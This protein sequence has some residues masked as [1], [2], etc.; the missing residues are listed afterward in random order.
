MPSSGR[1]GSLGQRCGGA[2][3]P[4]HDPLHHGLKGLVLTSLIPVFPTTP[5]PHPF[6]SQRS[7]LLAVFYKYLQASHTSEPF[8]CDLSMECPPTSYPP[9]PLT[10]SGPSLGYVLTQE[11]F[12]DSQSKSSAFSGLPQSLYHSFDPPG[13][14]LGHV[15]PFHQIVNSLGPG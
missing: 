3:G 15:C 13:G 10:R 1:P 14:N 11:D 4:Q 6:K 12:P 8:T 2:L 7:Q 5:A 9:S